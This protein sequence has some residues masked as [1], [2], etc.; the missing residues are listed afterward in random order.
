MRDRME[1]SPPAATLSLAQKYS[2]G[3][4]VAGSIFLQPGTFLNSLSTMS[5]LYRR[6]GSG[7]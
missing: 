5:S 2:S 4:S 6:I 7:P 3:G 1:N